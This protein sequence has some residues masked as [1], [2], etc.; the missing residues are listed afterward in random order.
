VVIDLDLAHLAT[1]A[2][3]ADP[4]GFGWEHEVAIPKSGEA[5]ANTKAKSR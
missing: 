1:T 2:W 4:A 3:F 5:G